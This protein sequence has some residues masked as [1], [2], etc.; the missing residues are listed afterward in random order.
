MSEELR[1]VH[2]GPVLGV[3]DPSPFCVKAEAYLRMVGANYSLVRGIPMKSPR[4]QLPVLL[5]QGQVIAGSGE[6]ID[7][8]RELHQSPVDDWLADRQ[9]IDAFHLVHAVEDYLYFCL[10]Y[11]RWV[12]P[13]NFQVTQS[14]F[15][16]GLNPVVTFFVSRLVRRQARQRAAAHGVGRYPAAEIDRRAKEAVGMLSGH[17]GDKPYF[18]GDEPCWVDCSM[19]GF[20]CNILLKGM[21]DGAGKW[22]HEF[23][24]LVEFE[25]RFRERYF[26]DFVDK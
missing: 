4:G 12:L 11:Q 10:L 6:I 8:V 26:A 17:L 1:L 7:Y 5:H 22:G 15:F 25:Q 9:R 19:Y 20:V 3:P 16:R 13:N 18:M 21:P 14:Y 23:G 2:F 24:N